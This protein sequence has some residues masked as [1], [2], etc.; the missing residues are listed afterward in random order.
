[1]GGRKSKAGLAENILKGCR[2]PVEER[3]YEDESEGQRELSEE[4]GSHDE[5]VAERIILHYRMEDK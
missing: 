3:R 4:G 5:R 2:V 1:M